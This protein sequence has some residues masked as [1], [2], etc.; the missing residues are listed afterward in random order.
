MVNS[1]PPELGRYVVEQDYSL[2]TAMDQATWRFILKVSEIFFARH[3]HPIYAYGLKQTGLSSEAIPRIS[4]IDEC[5]K[6]SGWRAVAV[7]GFIPPSVFL[8]MQAMGVLPIACDIRTLEHLAYT[9]APDIVHEA[10]GHAPFIVDAEY[11]AYLRA[12]AEIARKAIFTAEDLAVYEAVRELSIVKE[13]PASTTQDI[14]RAQAELDAA[15][16]NNNYLSEATLLGRMAWWS[17]EYG[18]IQPGDQP[19][20][21]GAGLLSSVAESNLAV[22]P[23][24]RKI[25]FSIDSIYY[26]FDITRP[27][28]Q[29][30]V[31]PDFASL[32]KVLNQF[33]SQMAYQVGGP[34]AL[35]K[36]LRARTVTS[37]QL[38]SGLQI[39][40]VLTDVFFNPQHGPYFLRYTGPVQLCYLDRELPEQGPTHHRHG[41]S[42]PLG[43]LQGSSQSAADLSASDLQALG[44]KDGA[45]GRLRFASGVELVG[46]L[47]RVS[48]AQNKKNLV[49]TFS[50]CTVRR[51]QEI[52]FKPEWGLFDLACGLEVVSVFGGAADRANYFAGMREID[53]DHLPH[54]PGKPKT[55][56][57]HA[58]QALNSLYQRAR[59]LRR[60]DLNSQAEALN[61]REL[62][63]LRTRLV[64][65]Y[66]E[67]WLLSLELL[68]LA[69]QL[70]AKNLAAQ[71][72]TDL[73]RHSQRQAELASLIERGL[74]A[75]APSL[76]DQGVLP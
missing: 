24:V 16:V 71:L 36:A 31:T 8:E 14:A 23:S 66:P 57:T 37:S 13:D 21:F 17:T 75:Y 41:F 28:Q 69:L 67:D 10:A 47:E 49:I 40:G 50:D 12:Y 9:P 34:E 45:Q 5:L 38:D 43:P 39:S 22:S 19:M 1:L 76:S 56:L 35:A 2:Y 65:S 30:F 6:K 51:A 20:I 62:E 63:E 46:R 60:S 29:L 70:G 73:R 72:S 74:A 68:E 7:S 53:P 32:M 42:S 58:N 52:L 18:L 25:P 64:E 44:F 59:D 48:P 4:E 54:A 26:S 33:R 27:Q 61:L 3:A 11:S 55:N 15:L